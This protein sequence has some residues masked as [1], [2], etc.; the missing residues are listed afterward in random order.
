MSASPG[1]PQLPKTWS[2]E[3]FKVNED[4]IFVRL[5]R[6]ND[7]KKG[8]LLFVVHGYGEY[9]GRY[10]HFP[11]YLENEVDAIA[12]LDL[13]G[14][15]RS[16]GKK[17]FIENFDEYSKAATDAFLASV[18]WMTAQTGTCKAHWLGHSLGGLITLRTLIGNSQLA[19]R[20]VTVSAPLLDLALPVP[21]IKKFFGKLIEPIF[22]SLPLK[23]DLYPDTLSHDVA[24]GE[25]YQND[26][27][28]HSIA[29]PRFFVNME[30]ESAILRD[31]P[32]NM[33]FDLLMITPLDDEIVSVQAQFQ[34]FK[35]LVCKNKKFSSFPNFRHEAFN[36]IGKERTFNALS[37]WLHAHNH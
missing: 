35:K 1:F 37:D 28:N 14:H 16:A 15:G 8:R 9:S 25:A 20:S 30:K 29:T 5:F 33:K 2:E 26:P 36:E 10:E 13:P 24:V 27:L 34:F 6:K 17:G 32:Q 22:G 4:K 12:L 23:S 18:Q 11:F 21:P 31:H 3:S 7:L 19:I